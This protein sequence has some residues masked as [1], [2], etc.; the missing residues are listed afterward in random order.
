MEIRSGLPYD[1][2]IITEVYEKGATVD[3]SKI[4]FPTIKTLDENMKAAITYLRNTGYKV[5]LDFSDMSFEQ[6]VALMKAYLDTKVAYDIPELD[7]SWIK[8]LYAC[9]NF[10]LDIE[11]AILNDLELTCFMSTE[12]EYIMKLG[13]FIISLPVYLI[14]RLN[15]DI[16][17]SGIEVCEDEV[18]VVNLLNIIKH[19]DFEPLMEMHSGLTLR[20]YPKVFTEENTE[21]FEALSDTKFNI[22]LIGLVSEDPERFLNFL[23]LITFGEYE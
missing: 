6:K 1:D 17:M 8:L 11:N 2:S 7:N 10:N 20:D 3:M 9:A 5:K 16:D 4:S 13:Y 14:K 23:K 19:P 21:L 18:N 22:M 12:K 15:T